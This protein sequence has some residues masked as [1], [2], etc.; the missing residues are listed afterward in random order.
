MSFE[1]R[2]DYKYF[3]HSDVALVT[4]TVRLDGMCLKINRLDLQNDSVAQL[5]LESLRDIFQSHDHLPNETGAQATGS[6]AS[7]KL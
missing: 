6:R 5:R 1:D 2:M 7:G 3:T 4:I